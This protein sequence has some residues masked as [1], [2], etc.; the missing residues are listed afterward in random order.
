MLDGTIHVMC[1]VQYWDIHCPCSGRGLTYQLTICNIRGIPEHLLVLLHYHPGTNW[2]H[3]SHASLYGHTHGSVQP[4]T[5]VP[6]QCWRNNPVRSAPR[7]SVHYKY[8][9]E[10]HSFCLSNVVF[11]SFSPVRAPERFTR[12]N[13]RPSTELDRY[14][15]MTFNSRP[16]T[17][18]ARYG[19]ITI[20]TD[21]K[22]TKPM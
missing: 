19:Q 9:N 1:R 20:K 18:W 4:W 17:E 5:R 13:P 7:W 21:S 10:G 6:Q 15:Q 12:I 8:E 22:W 11:W 16:S 3:V 2:Q 14:G